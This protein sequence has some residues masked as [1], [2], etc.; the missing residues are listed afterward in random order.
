[1]PR[2]SD[3]DDATIKRLFDDE[4]RNFREIA[5]MFTGATRNAVAGRVHR[6]GLRRA[7]A[8]K[9]KKPRVEKPNAAERALDLRDLDIL[10]D[11]AEGHAV[12]DAA[13]H[14]GVETDYVETL[15]EEAAA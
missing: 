6:L 2:W 9:V 10:Y 12:K 4:G 5:S 13:E 7:K 11:L 3:A 8:P 1:M 15:I 14:W